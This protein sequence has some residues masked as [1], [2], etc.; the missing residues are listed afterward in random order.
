MGIDAVQTKA[1]A[2]GGSVEI[3]SVAGEGTTFTIRLPLTLA[4]VRA[5]L[6]RVGDERYALPLTHVR[7]TLE[8]GDGVVQHVKGREVLVLRDEVLPLLRPARRWCAQRRRAAAPA[9]G[10]IDRARAGRPARRAWWWT[11]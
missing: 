2:L 8:Y 5:L 9:A 1:R 6:A 3:R 10:E 4:I 11:S 7:E